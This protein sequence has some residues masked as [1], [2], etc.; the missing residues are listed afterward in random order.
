MIL[1][2]KLPVTVVTG[3][4]GGGKTKLLARILRNPALANTAVLV[5]ELGEIGLEHHLLERVDE[6]TLL[7]DNGCI[8]CTRR[9]ELADALRD[10]LKRESRA[11]GR[12]TPPVERV[13]VERASRSVANPLHDPLRS[14]PPSSLRAKAGRS[15]RGRRKRPTALA[16]EPGVCGPGRGLRHHLRDQGRPHR[17]A[18]GRGTEQ[19]PWQDKSLGESPV[20]ASPRRPR[21]FSRNVPC[22]PSRTARLRKP[23]S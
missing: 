20:R 23:P 8:C 5:N 7:L 11:L 2:G 13:V 17:R 3:F 9:G 22:R 1:S 21:A 10:L 12:E 18:S 15:H 4:L 6:T 14:R 19:Q 16:R